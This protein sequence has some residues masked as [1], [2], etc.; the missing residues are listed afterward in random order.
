MTLPEEPGDRQEN[1]GIR[2]AKVSRSHSLP[3]TSRSDPTGDR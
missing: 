3:L 2:P 1:V